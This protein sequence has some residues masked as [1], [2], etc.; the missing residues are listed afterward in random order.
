MACII[1]TNAARPDRPSCPRLDA[2]RMP[3]SAPLRGDNAPAVGP[4][5][6][7]AILSTPSR[8]RVPSPQAGTTCAKSS[9]STDGKTNV[10]GPHVPI[11]ADPLSGRHRTSLAQWC[12]RRSS[13]DSGRL[14]LAFRALEDI[15]FRR[16]Q[17]EA[18]P[19]RRR[20]RFYLH[21]ATG[22]GF[23]YTHLALAPSYNCELGVPRAGSW[24][25]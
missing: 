10:T 22:R 12:Q 4:S 19:F 5:V 17:L 13:R 1:G 23:D 8:R 25:G 24:C 20:T 21:T 6:K 11:R 14:S 9:G 2:F 18:R 3:G 7:L 16:D 15:G